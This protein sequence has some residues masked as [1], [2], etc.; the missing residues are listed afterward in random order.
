MRYDISI[1]PAKG[2][3]YLDASWKRP[4]SAT[5]VIDQLRA[6]RVVAVDLNAGHLAATVMDPSGNPIGQPITI[7]VAL[8]G[9]STTTRDGH[10]RAAISTLLA[11]ARANGC[12]VVVIEDL[13]FHDARELGRERSGHRSSRWRRGRSF[14]RVVSGMPTARFGDRLAQMATNAGLSVIAVDPAYRSR[15][16]A[17][18]LL[19]SL[20][21][22]S[23][24]ASGH[25]AAALVIERRGLRQRARQQKRCDSTPAEHGEKKSCPSG[26]AVQG[27]RATGAPVRAANKGYRDPRGPRC[28]RT[29]GTRPE[30]PN[31]HPR[32]T[33][34]PKTVRGHPQGGTQFR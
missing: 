32:L 30:R 23:A 25:H 24:D 10:L 16:G 15:W 34:R 28:S 33:R 19:G 12:Q 5:P 1:D 31:G 22:I 7:P 18:H 4:A 9:L 13:D 26:R 29:C 21:Q 27:R 6:R 14:R 17:E 8:A 20:Q 3:W 2:R 11:T